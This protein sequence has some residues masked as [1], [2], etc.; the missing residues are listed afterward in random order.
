MQMMMHPAI[1]MPRDFAQAIAARWSPRDILGRCQA[2]SADYKAEGG[3]NGVGALIYRFAHFD[4]IPNREIRGE[5]L[6]DHEWYSE[7]E[8]LVGLQ[9]GLYSS[10]AEEEEQKPQHETAHVSDVV[11]PR[12]ALV[13]ADALTDPETAEAV[14]NTMELPAQRIDEDRRAWQRAVSEMEMVL[15]ASTY[16]TWLHGQTEFVGSADGKFTIRTSSAFVRDWLHSRAKKKMEAALQDITGRSGG[17]R[18]SDGIPDCG[19]DKRQ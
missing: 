15:P 4:S 9:E 18:I 8:Y 17:N 5:D 12:P 7:F 13:P 19:G 2:Y 6:Y 11:G 1:A 3:A 14:F 16:H 10:D